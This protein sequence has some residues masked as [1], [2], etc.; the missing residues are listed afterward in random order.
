MTIRDVL[1]ESA[2]AYADYPALKWLEHKEIKEI[3]YRDLTAGVV[4]IRHAFLAKGLQGRHVAITGDNCV[5]WIQSYLAVVTGPMTIVPIDRNLPLDEK[6]DLVKRSDS[7]L[8]ILSEKEME[9]KDEFLK[10]CPELKDVLPL[11]SLPEMVKAAEIPAPAE[12]PAPEE[13]DIAT[14]IWTSGTT[15]KSKG[16]CLTQKN[17]VENVLHVKVNAEPGLRLLSVLP[18]HHAYCLVMDYL[19]GLYRG[20]CICIND[21]LLHMVRNLSVFEPEMVLMVPLMLETIWKKLRTF[22]EDVDTQAV[23]DKVF[24]RNLRVIYSGGA[25]LD[26]SYV[27]GFARFHVMVLEGYGMSECSPVIAQNTEEHHKAGTVGRPLDNTTVKI[28]NGEVLVKSPS[29]M[30]GYYNMPEET[31]K[32]LADG[33]LHTGD[34]GSIDEDGFLSITGRIKNLIILS[35]GENVAPEGIENT[36]SLN[37]LVGEVIITGENNGLTAR[38]YPDSDVVKA[39]NLSDEDVEKK[40][41][42]LIDSFNEKEPGFRRITGLV[43]RKHPFIKNTTQK[44]LRNK[45]A[46][47]E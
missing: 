24:G 29:V 31:A 4:A 40:L 38:I 26:P 22:P 23:H 2:T 27:E 39:M 12:D 25:H 3:S 17:L 37:P 13:E 1:Q 46:I 45:A 44:I 5:A 21:S 42:A 18:I 41:Q 28:E 8:L 35:N 9:A 16:V 47:D 15:G 10:A 34:Q 20:A 33:W 11:E 14:I 32:T 36:L 6:I 30:K 19:E 7:A 43:V